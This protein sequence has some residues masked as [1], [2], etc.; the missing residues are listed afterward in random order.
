V[1]PLVWLCL[2]LL[3]VR[4]RPVA[5]PVVAAFTSGLAVL[6]ALARAT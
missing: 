6:S 2:G 4:P 1:L 3:W 5:A